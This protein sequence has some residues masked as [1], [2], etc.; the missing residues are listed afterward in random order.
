[1]TLILDK[2]NEEEYLELVRNFPLMSIEDDTHLSAALA[3]ID[4]LVEKPARSVA[5]NVYLAALTDLV[6][7]YE[8][9]HVALPPVTGVEALRYLMEENG[10]TQAD[11]APLF[12]AP[13]I[14]S[15]ALSGKR[16]I[17]LTHA[18]R[19]AAHFGL[20]VSVFIDA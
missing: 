19:L 11:L 3:V 2:A 4:G 15:E 14:I 9:A 1:M 7:I 20:P 6:E 5:E 17:A 16:R 18:R 12:G 8:N 13:S 10:L